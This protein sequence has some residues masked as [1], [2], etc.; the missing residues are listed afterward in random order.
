MLGAHS[1][2]LELVIVYIG[3]LGEIH[4]N[5][6]IWHNSYFLTIYNN[7]FRTETNEPLSCNKETSF[8]L[9]NTLNPHP[10]QITWIYQHRCSKYD[11]SYKRKLQAKKGDGHIQLFAGMVYANIRIFLRHVTRHFRAD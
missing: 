11:V 7:L 1:L 2:F 8:V 4:I 9:K 6:M 3:L 5:K 10:L